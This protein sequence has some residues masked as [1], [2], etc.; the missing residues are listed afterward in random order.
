MSHSAKSARWPGASLPT[1][2][3][4]PSA[5]AAFR[6]TPASASAGVKPNKVHAMFSISSSDVHGDV[7]GLQSVAIAIGTPCWRRLAIGGNRVSRRK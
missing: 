6:V 7:P 2:V 5:V 3:S 4:M 1:S